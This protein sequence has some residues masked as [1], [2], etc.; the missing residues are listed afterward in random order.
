MTSGLKVIKIRNDY[1]KR[2]PA[3]AAGVDVLCN[4]IPINR[5]QYNKE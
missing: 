1:V 5:L 2:Y 3:G 4:I